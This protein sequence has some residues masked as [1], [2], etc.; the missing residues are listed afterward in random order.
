VDKPGNI[1]SYIAKFPEGGQTRQHCFL[2]MFPEGGKTTKQFISFNFLFVFC[3]GGFDR[4]RRIEKN[5]SK[6]SFS[7]F[8]DG[9]GKPSLDDV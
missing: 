8:L 3:S 4:I 1:V 6:R 5:S 7:L 9:K 2:A